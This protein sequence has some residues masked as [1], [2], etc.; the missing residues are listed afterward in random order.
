MSQ[1]MLQTRADGVPRRGARFAAALEAIRAAIGV[2]LCMYN[3]VV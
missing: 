2:R 3:D 1:A